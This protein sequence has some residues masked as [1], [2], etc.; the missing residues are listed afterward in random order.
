MDPEDLSVKIF[1]QYYDSPGLD[2][3]EHVNIW[4][5]CRYIIT[6]LIEMTLA[7]GQRA[8]PMI[9]SSYMLST[10]RMQMVTVKSAHLEISY[11]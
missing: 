1:G 10:L 9:S 7:R 4:Y 6:F 3:D 8:K 2:L 11:F 5:I